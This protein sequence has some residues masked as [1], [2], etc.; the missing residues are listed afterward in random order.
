MRAWY[1]RITSV[2]QTENEG[3]IPSARSKGFI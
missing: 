1:N 3:A 2:Y